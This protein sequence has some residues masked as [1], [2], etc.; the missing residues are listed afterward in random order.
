MQVSNVIVRKVARHN[1]SVAVLFWGAWLALALAEAT[2]GSHTVLGVLYGLS[3]P[4]LVGLVT[5]SSLHLLLVFDLGHRLLDIA[6][7]GIVILLSASI[8]TGIGL[9]AASSLKQLVAGE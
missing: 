8:I 3:L 4:L 9:L 6:A 7:F 1:L 2:I 5:W